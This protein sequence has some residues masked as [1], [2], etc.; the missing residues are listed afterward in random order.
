[1]GD[2][3]VKGGEDQEEGENGEKG[4][5]GET[6]K[7]GGRAKEEG[8]EGGVEGGEGI[9]GKREKWEVNKEQ[10]CMHTWNKK[11]MVVHTQ[12]SM[13]CR[14]YEV[15]TCMLSHLPELCLAIAG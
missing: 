9:E 10:K 6:R 4:D 14:L 3:R 2:K 12:Y 15:C 5:Q 7:E 11:A 13:L 8:G 1:M